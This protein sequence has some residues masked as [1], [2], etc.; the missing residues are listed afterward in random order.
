MEP[1]LPSQPRHDDGLVL[2]ERPLPPRSWRERAEGWVRW[3]GPGR[4]AGSAV[5]VLA[6]LAGAYW[7]VR[8]PAATSESKLPYAAAVTTVTLEPEPAAVGEGGTD[9]PEADA[10]GGAEGTTAQVVVHVAG[11]VVS[12][13]VYTLSG[14]PRVIDAVTAAGGLAFDAQPDAINLAALL[15]DGQRV[16]VPHLGEAVPIPVG[17]DGS[18]GS[19][20]GSGGA[21]GG[22]VAGPVNL[23][24]ATA[25]QLDTLPG[26]GPATAAAIIAHREQHGP[27]ATVDDLADVRGIGPA[28]L[29]ALRGLVTV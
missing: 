24:S 5:I 15:A 12:P 1:L 8:P 6:V 14:V 26:V 2:P 10:A 7:L 23:N 4:L 20:G 25:D 19:S 29:D 28:K 17:I 27:F 18:S 9:Q 13:G 11:A 21:A 16:Y 3:V 22:G